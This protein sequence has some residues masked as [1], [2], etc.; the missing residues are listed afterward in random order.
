[1]DGAKTRACAFEIGLR[2]AEIMVPGWK[3]EAGLS[4]R[5]WLWVGGLMVRGLGQVNATAL[6]D[7]GAI[8][9]R[10][11]RAKREAYNSLVGQGRVRELPQSSIIGHG[12][13]ID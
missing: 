6:H 1:L 5:V 9:S 11:R 2:M 12:R 10:S 13:G 8:C 3:R 4:A 7:H